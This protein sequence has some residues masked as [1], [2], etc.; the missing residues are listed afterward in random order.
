VITSVG[1]AS[2]F[3]DTAHPPLFCIK[4]TGA[5]IAMLGTGMTAFA[6]AGLNP[7]IEG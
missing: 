1:H 6:D 3:Y 5:N 7:D 2:H 4:R